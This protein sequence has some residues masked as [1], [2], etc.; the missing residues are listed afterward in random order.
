MS[1]FVKSSDHVS[2]AVLKRSK[3]SGFE[4]RGMLI[5]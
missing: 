5:Q 2:N 3:L 1:G 4:Q